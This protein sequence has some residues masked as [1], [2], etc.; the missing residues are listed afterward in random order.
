MVLVACDNGGV[1]YFLADSDG[2]SKRQTFKPFGGVVPRQMDFL[3]GGVSVIV[4]GAGRQAG[5][6][7]PLPPG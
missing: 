6:M 4:T 2:V 1:D 3:F 5:T 7:E